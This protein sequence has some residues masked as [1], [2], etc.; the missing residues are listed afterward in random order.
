MGTFHLSIILDFLSEAKNFGHTF[1]STLWGIVYPAPRARITVY[2]RFMI[3]VAHVFEGAIFSKFPGRAHEIDPKSRK[4]P[5]LPKSLYQ[6]KKKEYNSVYV[7]YLC[8]GYGL[9]ILQ[10]RITV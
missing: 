7:L 6:K 8:K 3:P 9:Y 1:L 2:C 10:G 4:P 5:H